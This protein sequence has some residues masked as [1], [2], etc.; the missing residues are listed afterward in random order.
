MY[1]CVGVWLESLF[2]SRFSELLWKNFLEG[3]ERGNKK[4]RSAI[5]KMKENETCDNRESCVEQC[6]SHC[7]VIGRFCHTH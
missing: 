4:R 5:N 6:I 1:V 7:T 3:K 2:T